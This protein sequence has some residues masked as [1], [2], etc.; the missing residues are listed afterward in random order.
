MPSIKE[1]DRYTSDEKCFMVSTGLLLIFV[2]VM[3][4]STGFL[5]IHGSLLVLAS[6]MGVI[7]LC[8][9]THKGNIQ[10]IRVGK[11]RCPQCTTERSPLEVYK[12]KSGHQTTRQYR[13]V[14]T[15]VR[16]TWQEEVMVHCMSCEYNTSLSEYRRAHSAWRESEGTNNFIEANDVI[17][18][19]ESAVADNK[20]AVESLPEEEVVST[21]ELIEVDPLSPL[22][23]N[24]PV[25]V[26]SH[27][28]V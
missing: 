19:A 12:L 1:K 20:I 18:V 27:E 15:Q 8:S 17:V 22:N 3:L 4:V 21:L 10:V 2:G 6:S 9:E 7:K 28:I 13:V 26:A 16:H 5:I 14:Y 25:Q 23:E 11:A 24:A